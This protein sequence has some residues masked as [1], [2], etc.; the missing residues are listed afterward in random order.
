MIYNNMKSIKQLI[1]I[2]VITSS[3]LVLNPTVAH[4]EWKQDNQ[5]WWN[6]KGSSYSTGWENINSKWYYFGQD[7]YMAHD[8]IIDGYNIGSDGAW[9]QN[10]TTNFEKQYIQEGRP[11]YYVD[12]EFKN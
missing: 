5:G 3:I 6:T 12:A 7:G 1:A 9:I 8:T 10:I 2:G 11:I 4:A